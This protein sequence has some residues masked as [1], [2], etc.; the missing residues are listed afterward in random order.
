MDKKTWQCD[1]GCYDY[2][3]ISQYEDDD[4]RNIMTY[5]TIFTHPDTGLWRRITGA[6]RILRGKQYVWTTVITSPN[7]VQEMIE[8]LQNPPTTDQLP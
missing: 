3:T 2:L 7:D 4:P 6:W 5:I 8:M 1:A